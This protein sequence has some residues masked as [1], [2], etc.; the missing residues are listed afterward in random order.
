VNRLFIF[1]PDPL[2]ESLDGVAWRMQ[3]DS[4]PAELATTPLPGADEIWLVLPAGRVLLSRLTLS[5]KALRQLNGALGNALEDQLMFDPA[6]V[7]VALGKSMPGDTHPVAVIESAWLELAL[8]LC[9]RHSIEPFGAIPESL[10]WQ[11]DDD[12]AH[13]SVR[14]RGHEGF[15]RS[16]YCA[17]FA[18]DDGS[19]MTPPLALQLALAEARRVGAASLNPP[20][21]VVLETDVAVD[22]EAWS[23]SIDCPVLVQSLAIDLREP[24]INLLQ[25]LYASRRRGS[26]G[27]FADLASG[28]NLAKYQL[29]AGIVGAALAVHVLGTLADWARLSQQNRQLRAEMRQVFQETFPDTTAIV[30]PS[31]QMQRQLIDMRRARGFSDSGDFLHAMSAIAGQ[32]AGVSALSYDNSRLTLAQPRATD[33]DGLRAALLAQGYRIS[34][35]GEPGN[36]SVSLER[37]LP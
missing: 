15:V 5:R 32:V 17:G 30:D 18:I 11:G 22:I 9:R 35:A 2:P 25:G 13:W 1:L 26:S 12:S 10:L 6:Q 14:W 20:S 33:L 8:A 16:G 7:H 34:T 3:S 37:N 27:W 24:A 4:G 31:L 23:R 36:A 29:A 21:A 28:A 19:A